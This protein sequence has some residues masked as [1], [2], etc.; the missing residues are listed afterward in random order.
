MMHA[1]KWSNKMKLQSL[2]SEAVFP[3]RGAYMGMKKAY[4]DFADGVLRLNDLV[5]A[6]P[7]KDAKF[8]SLVKKARQVNKEIFNHLEKKYKGW[9]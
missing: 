5:G 9:D 6:I 8:E 4:Y 7:S 1:K 2:I 3:P